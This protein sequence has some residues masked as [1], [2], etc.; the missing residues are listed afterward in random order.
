MEYAS[1]VQD[2]GKVNP[3]G[4]RC[5]PESPYTREFERRMGA[6]VLN[7]DLDGNPTT[8]TAVATEN[9]GLS[10]EEY[11][12]D[13]GV[14][15]FDEGREDRDDQSSSKSKGCSRL[16][17]RAMCWTASTGEDEPKPVVV[18]YGKKGL[19]SGESSPVEHR[20]NARSNKS[21]VAPPHKRT[22]DRCND[23]EEDTN[24]KDAWMA[25]LRKRSSSPT[26]TLSTE[27]FMITQWSDSE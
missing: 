23:R 21:D 12:G 25:K 7:F 3:S 4:D 6:L 26:T 17:P 13:S 16:K 9:E 5:P 10:S 24:S 18:P 19:F 20:T 27:R 1:F 2:L 15:S 22:H 14:G 11:D 8:A